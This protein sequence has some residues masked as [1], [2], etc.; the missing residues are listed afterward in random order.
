MSAPYRNRHARAC[1]GHPRLYSRAGFQAW[2]AGTSPAMTLR[3]LQR[4]PDPIVERGECVAEEPRPVKTKF[5]LRAKNFFAGFSGPWPGKIQR[6]T[7]LYQMPVAI[8]PAESEYLPSAMTISAIDRKM[9][10]MS[11]VLIMPEL[12]ARRIKKWLARARVRA[13]RMNARRP[14]QF[15]SRLRKIIAFSAGRP[16]TDGAAA[17]WLQRA[18][19][20]I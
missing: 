16:G 6:P 11:V 5:L 18:K 13:G 19:G 7:K 17:R 2:M 9:R 15:K 8:R 3:N 14:G 12:R 10:A 20:E 4:F 1:R